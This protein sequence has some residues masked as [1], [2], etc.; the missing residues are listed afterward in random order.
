M[1][2]A[3][4][5]VGLVSLSLYI[6]SISYTTVY[7]LSLSLLSSLF[8]LTAILTMEIPQYVLPLRTDPYRTLC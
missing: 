3:V 7:N 6:S 4:C 5:V 8:F 2:T 1:F